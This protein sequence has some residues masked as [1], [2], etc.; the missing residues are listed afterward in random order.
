MLRY[1]QEGEE[2]EG[3]VLLQKSLKTFV[4]FSAAFAQL[5]DTETRSEAR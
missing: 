3:L 5:V 1:L 4:S 2:G